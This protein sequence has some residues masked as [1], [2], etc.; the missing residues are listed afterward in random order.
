MPTTSIPQHHELHR[1]SLSEALRLCF[2]TL[3]LIFFY[4]H[5]TMYIIHAII[6]M[7]HTSEDNMKHAMHAVV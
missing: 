1:S 2:L 6:K 7:E 4:I 5:S 3:E